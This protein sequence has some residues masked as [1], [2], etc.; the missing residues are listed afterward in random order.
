MAR[1][2]INKSGNA[3]LCKAK[4][5]GCPFGGDEAHFPTVEAAREAYEDSM[6]ATT[7]LPNISRVRSP[8]KDMYISVLS[9][10]RQVLTERFGDDLSDLEPGDYIASHL[11]PYSKEEKYLKIQ[12]RSDSSVGYEELSG[13]QPLAPMTSE[14]TLAAFKEADNSYR[15]LN[16]DPVYC[17][18]NKID[19]LTLME[20]SKGF[21]RVL[22]KYDVSKADDALRARQELE[23]VE[24]SMDHDLDLAKNTGRIEEYRALT[25]AKAPLTKLLDALRS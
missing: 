11:D 10:N 18:N 6:G 5:G 19:R 3:G 15:D 14:R 1:F 16:A 20:S 9:S 22:A 8:H 25:S 4:K 23:D 2:H 21:E 13:F 17:A 24:W 12:V 7:S